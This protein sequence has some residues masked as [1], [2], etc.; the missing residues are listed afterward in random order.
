MG[1]GRPVPVGLASSRPSGLSPPRP[2]WSPPARWHGR[3]RTVAVHGGSPP[4]SDTLPDRTGVDR[5]SLTAA[6]GV[7]RP[8]PGEGCRRSGR[9]RE[10]APRREPVG[11]PDRRGPRRSSGA[12]GRHGVHRCS[13]AR[14]GRDPTTGRPDARPSRPTSSAFVRSPSWPWSP[15][16][17][18]CPGVG[19]GCAGVDVSV[20]ISG[21][22]IGD[23]LFDGLRARGRL[24]SA[25]FC[26]RRARR[27][28]PSAVLVLVVTTAV[29]AAVLRPPEVP[30]VE[31][32]ALAATAYVADHRF[33]A[34]AKNYLSGHA[35]SPFLH[36]KAGRRPGRSLD[37]RHFPGCHN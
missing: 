9:H 27:L 36:P 18:A 33:A 17:P 35:T 23:D 26:T 37:R 7:P 25:G 19:G 29:S 20:V 3:P 13:C 15:S 22:L 10:G 12:S 16:A 5:C 21:Y 6:N 28:R 1:S 32:D 11:L 4:C 2:G 31:R 8:E 30:P 34:E 24:S 14:T